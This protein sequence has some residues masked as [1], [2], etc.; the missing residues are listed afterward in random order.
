MY[1]KKEGVDVYLNLDDFVSK[2][3]WLKTLPFTLRMT[4]ALEKIPKGH[5]HS[6]N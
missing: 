4:L 2:K 5:F 6:R 3:K 1:K